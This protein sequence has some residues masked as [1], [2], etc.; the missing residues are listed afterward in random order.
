MVLL[1]S[2]E[3]NVYALSFTRADRE[4]A[5]MATMATAG[6]RGRRVEVSAWLRSPSGPTSESVYFRRRRAWDRF[7]VERKFSLK[8]VSNKLSRSACF[9]HHTSRQ[10]TEPCGLPRPGG[11]IMEP[12]ERGHERPGCTAEGMPS[13]AAIRPSF[14]ARGA[15]GSFGTAVR[16][17]AAFTSYVGVKP[18]PV[19][20]LLLAHLPDNAA[21]APNTDPAETGGVGVWGGGYPRSSHQERRQR[22]IA[23]CY[24]RASQPPSLI[25]EV[26]RLERP[27][28][29][30]SEAREDTAIPNDAA[31][32]GGSPA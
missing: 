12:L 25:G 30:D 27:C 10:T 31:S 23:N 28:G 20:T 2:I 29:A 22:P 13:P 32:R 6:F 21:T 18:E 24:A 19:G 4:D 15:H 14:H 1:L 8:H 17:Q 3:E 11:C 5:T 26:S 7:E 9:A 16:R